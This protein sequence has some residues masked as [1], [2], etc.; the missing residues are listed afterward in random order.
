MLMP[1]LSLTTRADE[2]AISR[3]A[4]MSTSSFY[5]VDN[6]NENAISITVSG[7]VTDQMGELLIGVNVQVKGTNSGTSTD[8]EG[9]FTLDDV[10]QKVNSQ[11]ELDPNGDLK[12]TF[13]TVSDR[14][15]KSDKMYYI[16]I[17]RSE[18]QKSGLEQ[19][20]GYN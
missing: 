11:G 16:P 19:N 4:N 15:F 13:Y 6:S 7:I 8:F 2:V 17:P 5:E 12:G 18:I 20:V 3:K 14:N 10:W 1:L 9:H